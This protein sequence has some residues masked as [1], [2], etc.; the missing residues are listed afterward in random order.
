MDTMHMPNLSGYK[1]I[2]Q[3]RCSLIYWPEWAMLT[4]ETRKT[5]RKWILHGAAFLKALAWLE[6]H[7]YIKH[8][9]ISGYNSCANGLVERSH[10]EVRE[11]LFKACDGQESKWSQSAYSCILGRMSNYLKVNGMLTLFCCYGNA[12]SITH[13][14]C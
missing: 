4:R 11:A 2:V 5:L 6:K 14:Y 1:Y 8:I 9:R 3:G 13:Q 7:Y 12:P 10:F